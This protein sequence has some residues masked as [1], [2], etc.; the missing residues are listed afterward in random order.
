MTLTVLSREGL[1]VEFAAK[2][3]DLALPNAHCEP[4]PGS[5]YVTHG[6]GGPAAGTYTEVAFDPGAVDPLQTH[7]DHA[8][9]V[10]I[11]DGIVRQTAVAL[12]GTAWAFTYR[13]DEYADAIERHGM[14]LRE[15][16]VVDGIE[17]YS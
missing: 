16:V 2:L 9:I 17:V 3:V 15:R 10:R 13:P 7:L 4:R 8:S 6:L 5:W 12:Y 14:R 11:L 1:T